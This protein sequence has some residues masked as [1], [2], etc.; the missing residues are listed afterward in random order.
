MG[1]I[2]DNDSADAIIMPENITA[3]NCALHCLVKKDWQ[4]FETTVG[5][6][7]YCWTST[8]GFQH[9]AT[10]EETFFNETFPGNKNEFV[11]GEMGSLFTEVI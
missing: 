7:C 10:M 3:V 9:Y 6:R 4:Y 2:R 8:A 11:E 5:K 1:K